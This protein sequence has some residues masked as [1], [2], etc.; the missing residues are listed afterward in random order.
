MSYEDEAETLRLALEVE[1]AS[2][3]RALAKAIEENEELVEENA[4]LVA[5]N[6]AI[7]HENSILT[8][9]L[10]ETRGPY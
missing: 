7:G 9:Q 6:Q 5:E 10:S 2:L 3:T 8:Q 4:R 1:V